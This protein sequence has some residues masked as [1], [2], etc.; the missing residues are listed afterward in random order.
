[1][2]Q[3]TEF[4]R[5]QIVGALRLG[6]TVR[7]A[8]NLVNCSVS[9]A[10]QWWS[11]WLEEHNGR[12]QRGSGRPRVTTPRTDRQLIYLIR[13]Q[14]F[15]SIRRIRQQWVGRGNCSLRTTYRRMHAASIG[16]FRPLVRIPLTQEHRRLRLNWSRVHINWD[17]DIWRNVI[18]TDESRFVLDFADGRVRVHRRL[19]E[20]F[21]D[22]YI[23]Q[24]QR[25][26]GSS[27][28]VGSDFLARPF[29]PDSR[30]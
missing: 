19:T 25:Q 11:R 17:V 2:P 30:K 7:E 9:T 16:C 1:M 5:G 8:A 14:P 13:R 18:F 29:S 27:L 21:L 6:A 20:R 12:R 24:H 10:H 15:Q 4:E 22:R 26:G 28:M 3:L 23:V